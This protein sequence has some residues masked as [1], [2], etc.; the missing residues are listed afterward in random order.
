MIPSFKH[1]I[2]ASSRPRVV[3][4]VG[5]DVTPNAVNWADIT[6]EGEAPAWYYTEKQITGINQTI[7]LKV[8]YNTTFG[9]TLYYYVSSSP[10]SII[11][12]GGGT[13]AVPPTSLGMISIANNGT[14]TVSNNEYVTFG[15][16][17]GCGENTTITVKNQSDG[18]ST[19]DTM[20]MQQ[21][22]EC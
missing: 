15:A 22:G 8:E 7:T 14:F 17:I 11:S 4:A 1:G 10:G 18:D 16:I 21:I 13:D 20:N 19:M 12:G 6:Y 9:S 2:I 3:A 5:S